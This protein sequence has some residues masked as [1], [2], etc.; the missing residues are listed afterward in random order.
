MMIFFLPGIPGNRVFWS[1]NGKAS[2]PAEGM[3]ADTQICVC[4]TRND[5][6]RHGL[7]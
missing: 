2:S 6:G 4:V 5:V 3:E 1:S 7:A